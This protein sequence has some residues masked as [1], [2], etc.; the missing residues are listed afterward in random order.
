VILKG[1]KTEGLL[2]KIN[3]RVQLIRTQVRVMR[4]G[5]LNLYSS[6]MCF[7][8]WK[9]F[10]SLFLCVEYEGQ[11]RRWF[12]RSA[13]ILLL[14]TCSARSVKTRVKVT[15]SPTWNGVKF[16]YTLGYSVVL[17]STVSVPF[18]CTRFLKGIPKNSQFIK[19]WKF[20]S[21]PL[22]F[23]ILSKF[24]NFINILPFYQNFT[25]LPKFY[26]FIKI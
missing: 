16:S 11:L 17:H 25:I 23:T 15:G 6:I 14:F 1:L 2:T 3:T 26:N 19:T 12:D 10:S 7:Q 20:P 24:Y 5:P 4:K 22:N 18:V 21:P 13:R 9:I 8:R